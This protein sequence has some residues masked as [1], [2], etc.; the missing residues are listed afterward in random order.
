MRGP[1]RRDAGGRAVVLRA[2]AGRRRDRGLEGVRQGADGDAP[3]SRPPRSACSTT[4]RA[5]EAFIDAQRG[6]RGG[7]GRRPRRRQGRGGGADDARGQGRRAPHAGRP[8]VRRGRRARRD[9]GAAHRPRGVDDGALRRRAAGA[10][11]RR[12]RITRPS[13]TAT[14]GPNTGG[15]GTYSPSPLVDD[16]AAQRILETLFAP[17]V[18]ALAAAGRPFRGVLYG[19][20]ML[21][22]DRGPMVIEW[23]CRFGDPETQSVLMR[24][25][26]DLLPWLA[27]APRGRCRPGRPRARAGRGGLRGAGAAGYPESPRA[28]RRDHRPARSRADDLRVVPRRH[29]PRR[30][31]AGH[32]RRPRARRDGATAPI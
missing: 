8:R 29:A 4:S 22:P 20:L 28:R 30:R 12:P 5:A 21:T 6:Q 7:Q 24:L 16:A 26:D 19:G 1:R 17:T 11:A 15:M 31:S 18:R 3:A 9:R 25:D 13:A 32:R 10:A 2:V 27:G 23:N 14:R